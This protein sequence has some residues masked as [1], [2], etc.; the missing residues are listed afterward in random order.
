MVSVLSLFVSIP[1]IKSYLEEDRQSFKNSFQESLR[2]REELLCY[3]R[4]KR[5]NHFSQSGDFDPNPQEVLFELK[6]H[7]H[8]IADQENCSCFFAVAKPYPS[9]NTAMQVLF[10][11]N[12]YDVL[13]LP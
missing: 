7:P 9:R 11:M 5:K 13:M 8:F 3:A 4:L 10:Y 12:D 6:G 2:T 1:L